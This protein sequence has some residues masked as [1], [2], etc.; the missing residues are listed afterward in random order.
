[1]ASHARRLVSPGVCILY[2]GVP[3]FTSQPPDQPS[4]ISLITVSLDV[5]QD[6]S[7]NWD[8]VGCSELS[9]SV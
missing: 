3:E 9:H 5:I 2:L 7:I 4:W 8:S 1:M 6:H